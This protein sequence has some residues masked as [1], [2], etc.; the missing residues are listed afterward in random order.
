MKDLKK[1]KYQEIT[2]SHRFVPIAIETSDVLEA[3]AHSFLLEL[4][5]RIKEETE[6]SNAYFYLIQRISVAL[7]Q[8]NDGSVVGSSNVADSDL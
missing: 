8:R 7:Q 1:L 4:G 2:I 5:R 6:E 3:K